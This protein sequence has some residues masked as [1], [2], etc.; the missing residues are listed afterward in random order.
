[1]GHADVGATRE[2]LVSLVNEKFLEAQSL[3]VV[4]DLF[5]F[6]CALIETFSN[7]KWQ[8][9]S[10]NLPLWMCKSNWS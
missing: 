8:E 6:S 1:M 3:L 10:K 2:E 4:S 9:I 5:E 7:L